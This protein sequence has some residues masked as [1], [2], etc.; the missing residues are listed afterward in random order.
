MDTRLFGKAGDSS[1]SR[2][3]FRALDDVRIF[4]LLLVMLSHCGVGNRI[5]GGLG[6]SIF[7]FLSGCVISATIFIELESTGSF[8]ALRFMMR[9]ILKIYPPFLIAVTIPSVILSSRFNIDTGL[10]RAQ[11]FQYTNIYFFVSKNWYPNLIPGSRVIWSIAVEFQFY[12]IAATVI[13]LLILL[14]KRYS[15]KPKRYFLVFC[16]IIYLFSTLMRADLYQK[17][18]STVDISENIPRIYYMTDTRISAFM[19]GAIFFLIVS[20]YFSILKEWNF[21]SCLVLGLSLLIIS[22]SIRNEMFRSVFRFNMQEMGCSLVFLYLITKSTRPFSKYQV[23]RSLLNHLSKASYAIYL[24]H[25]MII[26]WVVTFF[27]IDHEDTL[28]SDPVPFTIGIVLA[29]LGGWIFY[30][31]IERPI[32]VFRLRFK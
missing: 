31:I 27:K 15:L 6:V 5:P 22:I 19:A 8:H 32:E 11:I 12:L 2:P 26:L 10:I 29:F 30:Q 3:N 28:W 1:F 7:F 4:G 23:I 9:R 16:V 18:S 21:R 13:S 14:G 20:K 17:Y 24:V 25:Y